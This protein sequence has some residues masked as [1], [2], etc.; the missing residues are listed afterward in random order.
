[1]NTPDASTVLRTIAD[2]ISAENST[3]T[4]GESGGYERQQ[5][6]RSPMMVLAIAQEFDRAADW[7]VQENGAIRQ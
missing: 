7:R 2:L 3:N 1:M 5:L 4:P 6:S